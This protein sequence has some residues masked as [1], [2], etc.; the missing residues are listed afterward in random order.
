[1]STLQLVLKALKEK[2]LLKEA[3]NI[4]NPS[5]VLWD[6][7]NKSHQ[8]EENS[9]FCFIS[10]EKHDGHSFA[11]DAVQRGA[12]VL[13]CQH[14]LPLQVPQ[15]IVE[16]SR[17]AMGFA[18]AAVYGFPSKQVSLYGITGTNGKT[19]SSYMIRSILEEAGEKCGLMGTIVYADGEKEQ[20]ADRTT[21]ESCD[22]QRLIARMKRNGCTSVIMEASSHGANQGRLNGCLFQGMVFTNLTP[23][24]LDY[25]KD[26]E[27]YFEAKKKLFEEYVSENWCGAV[28]S[29]DEYGRRLLRIYGKKCLSFGLDSTRHHDVQLQNFYMTLSEL[30]MKVQFFNS[31]P[32]DITLPL[33]GRFNIYNAL[34]AMAICYKMGVAPLV[35]KKGLESM[36]QVPGRLEKYFFE[37]EVCGVV[38]YAHTPDA[39]E[40]VLSALREV[41]HGKII[42]VF[43]HGGERYQANRPLLGQVAARLADIII[44]TMD[45]SRSEDPAKIAEAIEQGI[46]SVVEA[47]PH[48]RIL[49]RNEAVRTALSMAKPGDVVVVTGK[50]PERFIV[51]DN[52]KIEYNDSHAIQQWALDV[53]LRWR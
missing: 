34:G 47:P 30:S 6:V 39:L 48:Y 15:I 11:S 20:E 40:N 2:N 35:I 12:A 23:E 21:P 29:D 19:T 43:G 8:C 46:A 36:P 45:N 4:S 10:G 53:G 52:N 33:T 13:L 3:R 22:V 18:A 7:F 27:H 17:W 26:M 16:N 14:A 42:S 38:D 50:G 49:D 44:V 25:H 1:M 51:M 24:H 32:I 31:D 9:L 41:C 28:N 37:N 5:L